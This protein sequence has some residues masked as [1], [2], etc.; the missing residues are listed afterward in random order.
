[1]VMSVMPWNGS[2]CRAQGMHQLP[3]GRV[4]QMAP[5]NLFSKRWPT[6]SPIVTHRKSQR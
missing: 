4:V 3:G 2:R 5:M 6:A 1:M